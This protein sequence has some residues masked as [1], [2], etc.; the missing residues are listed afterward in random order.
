MKTGTMAMMTMVIVQEIQ[1][2]MGVTVVDGM[3]RIIIIFGMKE[4]VPMGMI[5]WMKVLM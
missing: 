2:L 4:K 1:I 5:M 3:M